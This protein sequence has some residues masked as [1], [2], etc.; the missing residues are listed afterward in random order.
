[1]STLVECRDYSS[2]SPFPSHNASSPSATTIHAMLSKAIG[3]FRQ[4]VSLGLHLEEALDSLYEV[5]QE[6]AE[7]DWDGYGALPV[8]EGAYYEAK[9]LLQLLPS[10]IPMPELLPEPSG[11]IGLEW[12]KGRNH[13]VVSASGNNELTFAGIFGSSRIHGTEYFYNAI[14]SI[15]MENLRRLS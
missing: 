1:M 11:D 12:R 8:S 10:S 9:K 4:T 2:Y 6:C 14:P 7:E 13:F 3:T 5:R 15:I